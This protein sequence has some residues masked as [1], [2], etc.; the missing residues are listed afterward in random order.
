VIIGAFLMLE[1]E[2]RWSSAIIRFHR[3]LRFMHSEPAHS[4]TRTD[5]SDSHH[6]GGRGRKVMERAV[7]E[8][9]RFMVMFLYL[10]ILFGLFALYQ[11]ILLRQEGLNFTAQGFALVN[12]LVLAK[13]MLIAEDLKVAHWLRSRPLIYLIL[14]ESLIF[15]VVFICFHV[16]EHLIIGLFKRESIAASIP[17]IGGGGMAGLVSVGL[18]LFVSLI[19]FFAFR[20]ISRELGPGRLNAMLLG[21]ASPASK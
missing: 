9:R 16:V 12:A 11:R 7:D 1:D 13:V 3:G 5:R 20:N 2:R 19:P 8:V 4:D 14:G 21:T 6:A 10:W 17:A 15:T 18:I